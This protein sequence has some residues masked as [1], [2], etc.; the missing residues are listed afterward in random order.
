MTSQTRIGHWGYECDSYHRTNDASRA[1]LTGARLAA[2]KERL[3]AHQRMVYTFVAT[4]NHDARR[5][6]DDEYMGLAFL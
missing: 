2:G 5:V 3:V 1:S 6:V 4:A